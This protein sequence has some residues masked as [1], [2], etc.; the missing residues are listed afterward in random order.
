VV[1][2]VALDLDGTLL[3]SAD[4]V[5]EANARAVRRAVEKGVAVVLATSRWYS[6]AKETAGELGL[7]AP[8]ICHTGALIRDPTNNDDLLHLRVDLEAAREVAAYSDARRYRTFV[9]VGEL[10][11]IGTSRAM[12]PTHL[13]ADVRPVP[14]LLSVLSDAPTA[15]LTFGS[16]A[17]DDLLAIF[18]DSYGGVLNLCEGYSATFPRYVSITHAQADKGSALRQ[19]CETVGI[20]PQDALAIGDA[21][22]DVAMFRVAGRSVAMGNAP[23]HVRELA[24]TVAPGND[25]DGVAWALERFVL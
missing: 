20:D 21:P 6:L 10:T 19:V 22:P 16:E 12:N 11:Y 14:E 5:S 9:T 7:T 18:G 15:F 8:L 1:R 24:D 2:I 3:D 17:V 4:R 13:P 25:D 23:A